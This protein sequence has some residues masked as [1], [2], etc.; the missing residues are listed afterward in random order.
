METGRDGSLAT[1]GAH[2]NIMATKKGLGFKKLTMLGWRARVAS[3][4]ASLNY[5]RSLFYMS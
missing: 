2:N 5:L 4:N 3:N 1:C